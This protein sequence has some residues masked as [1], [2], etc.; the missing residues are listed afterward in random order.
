MAV[1]VIVAAV[2][3]AAVAA[4]K[5]AEALR[6]GAERNRGLDTVQLTSMRGK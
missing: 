6:S 2:A 1:P 3:K 5:V 4:W